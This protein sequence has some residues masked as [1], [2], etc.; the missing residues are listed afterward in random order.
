MNR[1]QLASVPW[2]WAVAAEFGTPRALLADRSSQFSA[3]VRNTGEESEAQ[4][5]RLA[6]A[7]EP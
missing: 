5:R 1:V 6:G 7:H 3:L 2:Q 4:L